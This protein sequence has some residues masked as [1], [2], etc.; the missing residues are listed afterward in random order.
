MKKILIFLLLFPFCS[1]ENLD[2][3]EKN[4]VETSILETKETDNT[5]TTTTIKVTQLD[6]FDEVLYTVNKDLSSVSYLAPKQFLNTNLEIVEGF[7]FAIPPMF[8]TQA[9]FS[10]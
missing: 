9:G 10:I 7:T 8:K 5:S 6:S 4:S 1:S 2:I 3:V